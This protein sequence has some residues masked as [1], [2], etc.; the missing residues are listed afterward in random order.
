MLS[1]DFI[2]EY[3]KSL[4]T[5]GIEGRRVTFGSETIKTLGN[6]PKKPIVIKFYK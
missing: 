2:E 5:I 1:H 3:L 6:D 4:K